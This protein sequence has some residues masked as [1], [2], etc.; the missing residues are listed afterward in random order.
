M[1]IV[2]RESKTEKVVLEP[3][4][5]E[6]RLG[7]EGSGQPPPYYVA[8]GQAS[9][10]VVG[11]D[12]GTRF[13]RV[14]MVHEG[15]PVRVKPDFFHSVVRVDPKGQLFAT[16]SGMLAQSDTLVGSIRPKIGS[17]WRFEWGN[18]SYSPEDIS[19]ALLTG[20]KRSTQAGLERE[21][22]KVV[23]TVPNSFTSIQRNFL[24]QAAEAAG[25]E[26][27]QLINEPTAVALTHAYFFPETEGNFLIYSLGAGSFAASVLS[28]S[29]GIVEIKSS[30]GN[31]RLG[32]D[33]FDDLLL[34]W[35]LKQFE[36]QN[37]VEFA[38]T[39]EAL[40]RL[41]TAAEQARMDLT[42]AER[43]HIKVTGLPYQGAGTNQSGARH[44]ITS[45]DRET[46]T[47]LSANLLNETMR[48]VETV[49]AESHLE[50]DEIN[51]L[52]F[53]GPCTNMASIRERMIALL[54]HNPLKIINSDDSWPALG[55]AI[56]AS[57]LANDLR[58]FVT[59]DVLSVPVGIELPGGKFKKLIA[60]GTPLPV[61]AYHAF[62]SP[63][64]TINASVLQ[65]ESD[66]PE[67]N[68]PQADLIINNCPPT[69][70]DETKVEIAFCVRHDGII[71]YSARHIGLGVNLTVNAQ[72][73]ERITHKL[74][75]LESA[76]KQSQ[77]VVTED[78][79]RS[80]E[81]QFAA[82]AATSKPTA[83]TLR[84][85]FANLQ[86]LAYRKIVRALQS[87][88]EA[89]S[90]QTQA[91]KLEYSL[92]AITSKPLPEATKEESEI[93]VRP[94]YITDL[95]IRTLTPPEFG[96][97]MIKDTEVHGLVLLVSRTR[98]AYAVLALLHDN[99]C[100]V[101]LGTFGTLTADEAR[102]QAT[103]VI[104]QIANGIDARWID[105]QALPP[106]LQGMLS[107]HEEQLWQH[108]SST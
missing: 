80:L 29:N 3:L 49:L 50:K 43:A 33:D 45:I 92:A 39:S 35:M 54:P 30:S 9:H 25:L 47:G 81:Q 77:L 15:R 17:E 86:M 82:P 87:Q 26:V 46:L 78:A 74:S 66:D 52:L 18:V 102:K 106:R 107:R 56:Q 31:S 57:L 34:E 27:L 10:A 58:D 84:E 59:W 1:I 11:I 95:L 103:T 37:Q 32:G 38:Y 8:T 104:R 68:T 108:F 105:H 94:G 75:W 20:L 90:I 93:S 23:L 76:I 73:A 5:T 12:L 64:G 96:T 28:I 63:D 53:A 99:P 70:A 62:A 101:T 42:L 85:K 67:Q 14:A 7:G 48:H 21:I 98:I 24:K 65:G 19:T 22:S 60:R 2:E 88:Y 44:L 72:S 41:H 83:K 4:Q 71:H 91:A 97:L 51:Y 6:P 100:R 89:Q 69:A 36:E 79:V 55:A 61:T 13:A 40:A 16:G